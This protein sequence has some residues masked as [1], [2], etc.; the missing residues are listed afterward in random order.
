MGFRLFC[1][2]LA[3]IF[4]LSP[5]PSQAIS[6]TELETL[7]AEGTK[8]VSKSPWRIQLSG[9]LQRNL[10]IETDYQ[11]LENPENA[12]REGSLL[13]PSNLYYGYRFLV[14]YSLADFYQSSSKLSFLKQTELFLGSGFQSNFAGG[15]CAVL[16]RYL[17]E[18]KGRIT[19]GNYIRCGLTDISGGFTSPVYS[20]KNLFVFLKGSVFQLP[21]SRKSQLVSLIN[22]S[23][24]SL[25]SLYFF[26]KNKYGSFAFSSSHQLRYSYF[27]Y[28]TADKD[29]SSYNRPLSFSN[30][31]SFVVKQ[32]LRPYL[33]ASLRLNS[34]H[35]FALNTYKINSEA[36]SGKV[37]SLLFC[38]SREHYISLSTSSS[39]RLPHRVF[40][41]LS[42]TWRDLIS[43]SNPLDDNIFEIQK[44][45]FGWHNWYLSAGLSYSF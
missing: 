21:L 18:E 1:G 39:W 15:G 13:D 9:Y 36:C 24:G 20:A 25:E 23:S 29:G 41:S 3:L 11:A 22:S 4:I 27:K 10:E 33:P 17:D 16:A 34:S 8:A 44:H 43:V 28:L 35:Q 5:Q 32:K 30:E 38:G 26:K 12:V 37:L 42:A 31:L 6:E 40:F 14:Y 19:V 45:S 2:S 7:E